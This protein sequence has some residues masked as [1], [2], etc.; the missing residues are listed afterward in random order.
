MATIT[1]DPELME[2]RQD[3]VRNRVRPWQIAT[4]VLATVVVGLGAWGIFRDTA[5]VSA[6]APSAGIEQL[7]DAY[8]AAWADADAQSFLA[9]ISEDYVIETDLYGSFTGASQARNL[10]SVP[11]WHSETLGEPMM[12]G[13]G[14]WYVSVGNLLTADTFPPEGVHSV[15]VFKI[16]ENEG[17]LKIAAHF[18]FAELFEK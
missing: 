3:L 5:P 10:G 8:S 9:L 11:G 4:V 15:S 1:R 13:D 12:V 2:E 14:P 6:T 7:L 16:V 17:A 18:P